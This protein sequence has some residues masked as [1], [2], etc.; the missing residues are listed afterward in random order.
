MSEAFGFKTVAGQMAGTFLLMAM[1]PE[2][3]PNAGIRRIVAVAADQVERLLLAVLRGTERLDEVERYTVEVARVIAAASN[4]LQA[5]N[6]AAIHFPGMGLVI[7]KRDGSFHMAD[8]G[9]YEIGALGAD[10]LTAV[11]TKVDTS[12]P[13][14]PMAKASNQFH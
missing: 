3:E 12:I 9:E 2:A 4:S 10:G 8:E 6:D 13:N 1:R 11:R 7:I 5:G 14:V